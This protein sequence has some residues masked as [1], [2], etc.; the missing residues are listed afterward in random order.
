MTERTHQKMPQRQVT[1][2]E[3]Y[4]GPRYSQVKPSTADNKTMPRVFPAFMSPSFSGGVARGGSWNSFYTGY[5]DS[6]PGMYEGFGVE[7]VGGPAPKTAPAVRIKEGE[8]GG[9]LTSYDD[10]L[11]SRDEARSRGSINYHTRHVAQDEEPSTSTSSTTTLPK[12][13]IIPHLPLNVHVS[14]AEAL[15]DGS[16]SPRSPTIKSKLRKQ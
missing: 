16:L 4:A 7:Y 3:R 2:V 10:V 15:R 5:E 8:N 6:A 11:L 14:M 13:H 1:H 12:A 9:V